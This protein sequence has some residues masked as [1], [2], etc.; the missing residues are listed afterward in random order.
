MSTQACDPCPGPPAWQAIPFQEVAAQETRLVPPPRSTPWHGV[1][2]EESA[3]ASVGCVATKSAGCPLAGSKGT[4][5][6]LAERG[7]NTLILVHL[8]QLLDQWVDRLSTFLGV[9]PDHPG[10]YRAFMDAH[11][12]SRVNLAPERIHVIGNAVD[13]SLFPVR[14]AWLLA[15]HCAHSPATS[16]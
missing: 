13:A 15:G 12:F 16:R 3:I 9:S 10:S 8:R 6:L 5:W 11:L 14:D 7:V 2:V 1:Q 4:A